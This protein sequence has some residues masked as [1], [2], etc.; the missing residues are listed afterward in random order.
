MSYCILLPI[1]LVIFKHAYSPCMVFFVCLIVIVIV[2]VIPIIPEPD[3]L[4]IYLIDL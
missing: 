2:I 3:W 4:Y 1:H